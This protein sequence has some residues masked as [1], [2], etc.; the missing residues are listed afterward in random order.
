MHNPVTNENQLR[1][2]YELIGILSDVD[3]NSDLIADIKR[4]NRKYVHKEN[5]RHIVKSNGIDGYVVLIDLPSWIKNK[6]EAERY[7]KG[8]E[9]IHMVYSPYDCTG[10][11]F[12]GWYK[13]FQ[14]RN[15]WMAYHSVSFD[16]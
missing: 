12:T 2:N 15:K 11:P 9:Y 14:R 1:L 13:V 5:N 16:V 6:T 10:R 4:A 8:N 7:F 3:P